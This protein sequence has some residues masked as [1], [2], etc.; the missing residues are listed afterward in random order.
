MPGESIDDGAIQRGIVFE[1]GCN[2]PKAHTRQREIGN[3][4]NRP[5]NSFSESLVELHLVNRSY[6]LIDDTVGGALSRSNN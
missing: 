4:P 1:N 5:F 6:V 3:D 2:V